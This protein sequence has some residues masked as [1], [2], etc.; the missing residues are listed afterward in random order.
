[1]RGKMKKNVSFNKMLTKHAH[2]LLEQPWQEYPRPMMKRDS[3]FC[4][5]GKWEFGVR[6]KG[7]PNVFDKEI[8]V[9]FPPESVLSGVDCIYPEDRVLAYRKRFALPNGVKRERVLLHFG[10]VDQRARVYLN[11][12]LL[13]DH[14]GGYTPFSTE[15]TEC[16]QEENELIVEVEDHLSELVYPYGKQCQK[17]GGMWYTPVSGI[18]QTV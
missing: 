14:V 11:G 7:E 5:N 2:S 3:Y 10:A 17:R 13:I 15:I 4:L 6:K 8:L 18:W 9:P 12:T 16:L 1:M